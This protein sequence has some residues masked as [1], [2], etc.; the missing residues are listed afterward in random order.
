[1]LQLQ[2]LI[3]EFQKLEENVSILSVNIRASLNTYIG[4]GADKCNWG[5]MQVLVMQVS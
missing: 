4:S 3:M 5:K 2:Y 1:M